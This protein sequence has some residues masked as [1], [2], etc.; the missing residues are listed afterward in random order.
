MGQWRGVFK[1]GTEACILLEI[2]MAGIQA[3][4]IRIPVKESSKEIVGKLAIRNRN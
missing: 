4:E 2:Y 3:E 1:I